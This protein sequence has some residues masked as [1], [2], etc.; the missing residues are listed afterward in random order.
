MKSSFFGFK[1][2]GDRW[3]NNATMELQIKSKHITNLADVTIIN[4]IILLNDRISPSEVIVYSNSTMSLQT[5]IQTKQILL[6][7]VNNLFN[8]Y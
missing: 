6:A 5:S 3:N 2:V 7:Q 1:T 8:Q 4:A